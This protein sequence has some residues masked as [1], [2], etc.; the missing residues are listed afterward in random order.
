MSVYD[1]LKN[2]CRQKYD[3]MINMVAQEESKCPLTVK[4]LFLCL[5]KQPS[6]A[7][8]TQVAEI[9]RFSLWDRAG[10]NRTAAKDYR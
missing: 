7:G 4:G 10:M 6:F 3:H 5:K 2:T 1:W 9:L 8:N